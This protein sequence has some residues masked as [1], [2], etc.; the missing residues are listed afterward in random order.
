[1]KRIGEIIKMAITN[2]ISAIGN[3]S[4]VYPL[5]L[6]DCGIEV[7]TKLALTYDQNKKE[8]KEIA[9]LATRER[10]LDEYSSSAVWLGGI[11]FMGWLCNKFIKSKA[12]NPDVNLKLF[13]EEDGIQ[14]IDYNIKKFAKTAPDAVKDLVKVKGNKK[15]YEKLLAGKFVVSTTVPILFMGFILP[16]L[17]FA[18]SSKKI[19]KLREENA[20]FSQNQKIS[21]MQKDRFFKS[22][23]PSFTGAWITK[24][25]NFSAQDK[26]AVTDGGYAVGRIATARNKNEC[27]DLSFKMTGMMVLN[28][29]APKWIEKVLNKMTGTQ[30]D[31]IILADKEFV[32]QVKAGTL[33]LPKSDNAKDLLDFVDNTE[34]KDTPFIKFAKKFEKIKMLDNGI[35]DPREYVDIKGLGGF[36]ND[37]E[38]FAK[39]AVKS[40]N[41]EKYVKKAKIAKSANILTNVVLS[42]FLLAYVLPKAQFAFRK[43]VT[44]S[45]LEPGLA[46]A[47]KVVDKK[48]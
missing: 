1:M 6:R 34:N 23:T 27:M 16:K 22:Q 24:A 9:Y 12:L 36:R 30:L 40:D 28:Y 26:M 8:S 21:F 29:L 17:I 13:K 10:F 3:N 20:K 35:R 4:S 47:E 43:L 41:L 7:P 37:I 45:D 5:I 46:P 14:G 33:S 19:Q 25:A 42:S 15:L 44:G 31:P 11:P 39:Q 38:N 48:V 18:S 2:I 32:E